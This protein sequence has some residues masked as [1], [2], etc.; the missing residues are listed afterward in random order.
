MPN[1]LISQLL[2]LI[3]FSIAK[4]SCNLTPPIIGLTWT[5]TWTFI[6]HVS[7]KRLPAFTDLCFHILWS[8][9]CLISTWLFVIYK[10]IVCFFGNHPSLSILD[11]VN[12]LTCLWP[13]PTMT[14]DITLTSKNIAITFTLPF[15]R[16]QDNYLKF[17]LTRHY[18]SLCNILEFVSHNSSCSI[19]FQATCLS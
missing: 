4:F 10:A 5:Q 12:Q 11:W 16:Y 8:H 14:Q 7:C 1:N 3:L 13:F 19:A 17:F 2:P 15:H 9:I 18:Q 6:L